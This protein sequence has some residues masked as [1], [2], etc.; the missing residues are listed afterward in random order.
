MASSMRHIMTLS[1][2]IQEAS[3][4]VTPAAMPTLSPSISIADSKPLE[5]YACFT[6]RVDRKSTRLNSSHLGIS[7]AV[8]CLKKKRIKTH[9]RHSVS[10]ALGRHQYRHARRHL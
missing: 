5:R 10:A 4:S 7:Y 9:H 1:S 8:F 6:P 3:D 2:R